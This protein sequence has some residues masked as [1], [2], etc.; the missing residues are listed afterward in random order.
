M[1]KKYGGTTDERYSYHN[2]MSLPGAVVSARRSHDR[3]HTRGGGE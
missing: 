2:Q 3:L 1:Q